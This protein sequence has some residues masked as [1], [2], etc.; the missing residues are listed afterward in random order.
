M[1]TYTAGFMTHVTC[2][3]TAKDL[4]QLRFPALGNRELATFTFYN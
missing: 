3:L 4:D 2:R 1:A